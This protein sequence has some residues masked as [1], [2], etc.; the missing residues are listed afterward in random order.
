MT[1][2]PQPD[3]VHGLPEPDVAREWLSTM[4]LIRRFEERAGEMYA[5]AKVGGFLHLSIGEEAT[6]VGSARA[7][8]ERDYL[9]STYRSHGHALVRGTPPE[10]VMAELFGRVDGCSGG[11]GGSMHM[12]DIA[13][14]FMGGYGI[15]GGNLPIAAGLA[16][17]SDYEGSDDVTLCTFGDG[18]SNQGTFGETLNLAAL[19][20][21]PVLFMVTNNQ[22]G[23]G[24]ALG[25]HSAVTDLQR[26][27]ES[28]GV[29]GVRCD[30][31]DVLDTYAV[32]CDAVERVREERR[33]LLV[34]AVTYRFRGHSMADPEQYRSKEEVAQ[35]RERDPIPAFA[36]RLIAEQVI[37]EAE[38]QRIDAEAIARVDAAVEFA[39]ASPFPAPE[40]LYDDV[41]V[42]GD[43]SRGWYSVR[44]TDPRL[45]AEQSSEPLAF[46]QARD[47]DGVQRQISDALA[48]EE[49][50]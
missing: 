27:G 22:F 7:L 11:R 3:V 10:N 9:I 44:T 46:S 36:E 43:R 12:F 37:D 5:R 32:L 31:M 45:D 41:Y 23:M 25:R 38:R 50:A 42:L 14:R 33:P 47:G 4:T 39:E 19:W 26:K 20:K 13:R 2:S 16:L 8:R 15:V 24:T 18:A 17:A 6:I 35:W 1:E 40:S 28:L 49:R 29:P 30:G 21:L 34:E 48:R